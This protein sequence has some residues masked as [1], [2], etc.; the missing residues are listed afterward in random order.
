MRKSAKAANVIMIAPQTAACGSLASRATL[1]TTPAAPASCSWSLRWRKVRHQAGTSALQTASVD[2]AKRHRRSGH[3][4]TQLQ[5]TTHGI[6]PVGHAAPTR[7]S[8][9]SI[10]AANISSSA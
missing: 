7:R 9:R 2:A 1:Y 4:P 3:R 6:S 8:T 5:T 10:H